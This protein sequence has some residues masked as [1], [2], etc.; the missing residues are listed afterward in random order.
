LSNTQRI[1]TRNLGTRHRAGLGLSEQADVVVVI[2]SEERGS[3]S[4]AYQGELLLDI[5]PTELR[6]LLQLRLPEISAG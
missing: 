6:S 5:D 1:G 4:F 3:I 2:I